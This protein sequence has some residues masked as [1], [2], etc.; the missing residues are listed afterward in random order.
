VQ[1][2]ASPLWDVRLL[3]LTGD[4]SARSVKEIRSLRAV[5]SNFKRRTL[6]WRNGPER[7]TKQEVTGKEFRINVFFSPI[8]SRKD[9]FPA[10]CP[11]RKHPHEF[12]R[13]LGSK[14]L[15][16][17]RMA[18]LKGLTV[19]ATGREQVHGRS[20]YAECQ[21]TSLIAGRCRGW[22]VLEQGIQGSRN[23]VPAYPRITRRFYFMSQGKGRL[24]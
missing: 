14:T 19:V 11:S 8:L 9:R 17:T 4:R 15:F 18:T 22:L 6:S 10:A 23:V 3:L 13:E 20:K 16:L 2:F 5:R 12:E 21:I 24:I 1:N 7:K